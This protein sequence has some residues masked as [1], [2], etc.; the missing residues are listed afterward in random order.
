MPSLE[1]IV[2]LA[3]N[4]AIGVDGR[5]PWHLSA[6]LRHFKEVTM[7]HP[8][9][10]GRRTF[11]SIGRVLPGRFNVIVSST[12][13][14]ADPRLKDQDVAVVTS[15]DEALD[16]CKD[17]QK[18]AMVIGGAALYKEALPKAAVLHLTRVHVSPK[19]AD[20]FFPHF[21]DLNF[22]RCEVQEHSDGD[23]KYEFEIW[24]R[25]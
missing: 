21:E 8:V 22:K 16:L 17:Q 4:F 11:E 18:S 25:S 10:M 14:R 13:N 23:L 24:K 9:I 7:G 1:I 3:D 15:L 2:A 12:L 20:T 6:D 5:I 19:D